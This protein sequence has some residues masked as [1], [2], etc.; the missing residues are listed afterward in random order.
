MENFTLWQLMVFFYDAIQT[1]IEPDKTNINFFLNIDLDS[2]D[3]NPFEP[4]LPITK[5]LMEKGF[6]SSEFA[7]FFDNKF[8][9]G[10][11]SSLWDGIPIEWNGDEKSIVTFFV[12]LWFLQMTESDGK[13]DAIKHGARSRRN[14]KISKVES[15]NDC[16]DKKSYSNLTT[17]ICVKYN[18]R[19]SEKRNFLINGNRNWHAIYRRCDGIMSSIRTRLQSWVN[20]FILAGIETKGEGIYAAEEIQGNAHEG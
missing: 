8:H 1:K 9:I 14:K 2:F 10:I 16:D 6:L 13:F 17:L 7:E 18:N 3:W 11:G 5:P 15:N 12:L 19:N 20:Y 4:K